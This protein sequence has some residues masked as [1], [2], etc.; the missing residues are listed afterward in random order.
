MLVCVLVRLLSRVLLVR[1][2]L[3]ELP[4]CAAVRVPVCAVRLHVGEVLHCLLVRVPLHCVRFFLEV[5]DLGDPILQLLLLY[6]FVHAHV[7]VV[8]SAVV[9]FHL[10]VHGSVA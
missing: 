1:A 2:P 4:E 5:S 9:I 6:L 8:R 3:L 7:Q 10:F